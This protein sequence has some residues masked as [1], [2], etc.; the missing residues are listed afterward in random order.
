M[1]V[2]LRLVSCIGEKNTIYLL[3]ERTWKR[4]CYVKM[5]CKAV[6]HQ[7]AL[8]ITDMWEELLPYV[9]GG[10][11]GTVSDRNKNMELDV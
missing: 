5:I 8:I 9:A 4:V 6:R 3:E 1:E 2:K 7:S 10:N 11:F